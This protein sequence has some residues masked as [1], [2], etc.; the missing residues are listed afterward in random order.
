MN[1]TQKN[2][3]AVPESGTKKENRNVLK[4]GTGKGNRNVPKS[5]TGRGN[6]NVPKFGTAGT[7]CPVPKS[8]QLALLLVCL[9]A[10]TLGMPVSAASD[11]AGIVS[12]GFGI[13]YDIIAGIVS[14]VGELFLLWGMFEWAQ[15]LNTQDGGAQ[16][17]AFKRISS[18][19]VA[20]LSPQLIPL[21]T[22][23]I[24]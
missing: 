12:P 20:V 6:P 2:Q 14:S 15:A 8:W 16:S 10:G 23:A 18:G 13:I 24:G 7:G 21:V 19:L 5:G 9:T 11:A 1:R 17:M 22:A 4:S 3:S